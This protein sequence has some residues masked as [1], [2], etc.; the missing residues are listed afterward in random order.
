MVIGLL[1]RGGL[2]ASAVYY[3]N[4]VGIWSDSEQTEKLY[5]NVKSELCPYVQ[6]AKKQLPFDVPQLPNTGEMRFLAKHYYNEGV[7]GS[8][9]FVHMLPCYAGRGLKKVKDTFEDFAKSPA[10]TG[11]QEA[12]NPAAKQ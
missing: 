6:K 12:V 1:V 11:S 9:R 5:N 4:K 10:I 8:I 7:K 3:T 2:V